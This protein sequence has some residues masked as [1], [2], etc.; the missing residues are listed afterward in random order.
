MNSFA[1]VIDVAEAPTTATVWGRN[2]GTNVS[3]SA[4]A[5]ASSIIR[6]L[7]QDESRIDGNRLRRSDDEG[8]D[9]DLC[10]HV[11]EFD[12]QSGGTADSE[13][14]LEDCLLRQRWAVPKTAHDGRAPKIGQHLL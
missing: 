2:N 6:T 14:N 12:E 13:Q 4:A 3:R 7:P 9:V 5:L 1:R 10:D 8:I 11:E